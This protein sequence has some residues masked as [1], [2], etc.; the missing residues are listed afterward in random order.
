MI[1][2]QFNVFGMG[3]LSALLIVIF[4]SVSFA[5]DVSGTLEIILKGDKK[6]DDVSSA[7]VYLDELKEAT[8]TPAEMKKDFSRR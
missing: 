8:V 7:V 3:F 5:H 2:L 4:A 1:R 6:K